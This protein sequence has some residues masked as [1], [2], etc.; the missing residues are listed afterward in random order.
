MKKQIPIVPVIAGALLIV[1]VVAYWLLVSPKRAEA[2][3]LSDEIELLESQVQVATIDARKNEPA[4]RIRVADLF[5]L[6]KA[7]PDEE[8][9]P[10]V[11]LELNSTALAA[12]IEFVSIAPETPIATA[13]GYH[14]LPIALKFEGNY[15]DL[16]DFLFRLRNHVAV[17]D[18]RLAARGRLFTLDLLDFHE[19]PGGFPHIEA[20]LT[21]AAYVYGDVPAAATVAAPPPSTTTATTPTTTTTTTATP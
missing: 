12:G 5:A 19:G 20:N 17:R 16:T 9:M 13:N 10:G 7:M 15:F 18:G 8:D 2:G 21:V 11:I 14:V 6:A 1:A 3:R 4:V